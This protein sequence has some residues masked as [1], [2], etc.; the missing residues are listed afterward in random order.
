MFDS[1][2]SM[3]KLFLFHDIFPNLTSVSIFLHLIPYFFLF[4]FI[5]PPLTLFLSNSCPISLHLPQHL[6]PSLRSVPVMA[7]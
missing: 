4:Q 3:P 2:P 6:A 5:I 1:F 7:P